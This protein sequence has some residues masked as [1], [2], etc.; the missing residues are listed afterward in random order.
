MGVGTM[1]DGTYHQ[2]DD[3]IVRQR[4]WGEQD[5][6]VIMPGVWKSARCAQLIDFR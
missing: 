1:A 5:D 3:L 2:D 4:F 6:W